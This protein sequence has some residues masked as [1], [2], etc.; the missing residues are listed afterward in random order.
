LIPDETLVVQAKVDVKE[1][2][3]ASAYPIVVP[4]DHDEWEGI[5]CPKRKKEKKI[6]KAPFDWN[7]EE[8][9][10]LAAM[11][12]QSKKSKLWD[13]SKNEVD[14]TSKP[15]FQPRK[16]RESCEGYTE[17]FLCH[18]RLYV[19]ADKYDIGPL[20]DLSLYKLR[21]TL[22]EFTLFD[23]RVG[24]IINL[25]RYSYLNTANLAESVDSLRLLIIHYAECVVEDMAGNDGFRSLLKESGSLARDLVEQ[26]LKRLD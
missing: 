2:T 22:A 12:S 3:R 19:F 16:N 21:R 9:A 26:M 5:L 6:F 25:M 18:A 1:T 8:H 13:N 10:M 17:V 15:G 11:A 23:K 24:D 14:S 7:E 20:K 4:V